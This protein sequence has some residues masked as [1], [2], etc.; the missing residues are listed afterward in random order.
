MASVKWVINL[1]SRLL[2]EKMNVASDSVLLHLHFFLMKYFSWKML[3]LLQLFFFFERKSHSNSPWFARV[4]T[5]LN[6]N[7]EQSE[8]WF[9]FHCHCSICLQ[10]ICPPDMN[11]G[12]EL[13]AEKLNLEAML[14]F[15]LQQMIYI[16]DILELKCNYYTMM[17]PNIHRSYLTLPSYCCTFERIDM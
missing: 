9:Y 3:L 10:I 5:L 17:F 8:K 6:S 14:L 12:V 13:L 7:S 4:Y 2:N 11:V 15:R 16:L 1:R